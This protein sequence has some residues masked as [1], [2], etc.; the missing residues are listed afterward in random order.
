M[1]CKTKGYIPRSVLVKWEL[2]VVEVLK[3]WG[4]LLDG[5]GILKP[6]NFIGSPAYS[7]R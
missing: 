6:P 2:Q 3:L 1:S 5:E 7:G 4:A